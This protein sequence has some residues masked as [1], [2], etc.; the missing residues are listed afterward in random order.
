MTYINF[1]D[2]I[3]RVVTSLELSSITIYDIPHIVKM[4]STGIPQ[5]KILWCE[6]NCISNWGWYFVR[7]EAYIGFAD[8]NE[9]ISFCLSNEYNI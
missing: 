5:L 6:H 1:D 9:L 3:Q 7:G 2:E 8:S 4:G